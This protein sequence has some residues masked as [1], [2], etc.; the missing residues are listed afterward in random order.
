M[1]ILYDLNNICIF[2]KANECPYIYIIYTYI[3]I[4]NKQFE[5][6]KL[7]NRLIVYTVLNYSSFPEIYY[8]V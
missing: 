1:K 7:C 4:L 8:G 2:E 3:C 6:K 5:L